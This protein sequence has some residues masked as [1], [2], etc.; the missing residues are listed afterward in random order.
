MQNA[1]FERRMSELKAGGAEESQKHGVKK[2]GAPKAMDRK[3]PKSL[4]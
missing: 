3:E 1:E 2:M 4:E